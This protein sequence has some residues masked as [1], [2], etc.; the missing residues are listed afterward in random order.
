MPEAMFG[1]ITLG[2]LD[3]AVDRFRAFVR[4]HSDFEP[5][6]VT[7]RDKQGRRR[8]ALRVAL[9]TDEDRRRHKA[10]HGASREE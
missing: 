2:S 9:R 3:E 10:T 4:A 7:E 6:L 5:S 8:Y 1:D